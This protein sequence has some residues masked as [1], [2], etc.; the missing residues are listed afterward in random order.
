MKPSVVVVGS[1]VKDLSFRC[2]RFPKAGETVIGTF[3]TGPGG[4]GSNQ[5]VAAAR[6]GART[7]FIGAVGR[8]PFGAEAAQFLRSEGIDARLAAKRGEA[9]GAA[10]ILVDRASQNEIIVAIGASVAIRPGDVPARLIRGARVVICQGEANARINLHAF[11]LA[12]RFGATTILNPAP[13]GPAFDRRILA[14]TDILIPNESEF[15]ALTRH[16]PGRDLRAVHGMGRSLGVPT[17]IVTM[18]RG[19]CLV[20]TES[21]WSAIAGH[22]V[23]AVDTTGAGDAFVGGFAAGLVRF[24]GDLQKAARFGNA[25]AALSVTRP[26]TAPSMPRRREID[27]LLR[28]RSGARSS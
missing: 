12:R 21:G 26:G 18:G 22:R 6:A 2:S 28:S 20:S 9:T 19:G 8:D 7:R 11:G 23:R 4:K 13:M 5:A 3:S 14:L 25:A 15:A 16:A 17:I 10:A 27:R 24:G 1:F